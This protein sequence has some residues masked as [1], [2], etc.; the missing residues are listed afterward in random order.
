[1]HAYE[2]NCMTTMLRNELTQL[3]TNIITI[4]QWS[5]NLEFSEIN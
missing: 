1:M 3:N 5:N 4:F 2:K